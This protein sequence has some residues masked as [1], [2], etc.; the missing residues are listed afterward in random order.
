MNEITINAKKELV[1]EIQEKFG[2]A[3]SVILYDY[4]GL[5]VAEVTELRNQMRAANVEY[6]VLKNTMIKRAADELKIEGLDGYLN[7]PTAVAIGYDDPVAPAK[8]LS[9][10]IKKTKK[11]QIKGGVLGTQVIDV[12]KVENLAALPSKDELVAKMLG[13]MNAPITGLVMCMSGV[14]KSLLYA[15]N[16]IAEKKAN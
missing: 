10:F 1:S 7:G 12:K 16:G 14:V 13:S 3:Q 11:T 6:K 5:T 4:I 15:L 9:E 2:K 8:V